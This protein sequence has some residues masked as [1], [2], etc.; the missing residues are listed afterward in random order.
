MSELE[1]RQTI[2]TNDD[3]HCEQRTLQVQQY[4]RQ[5]SEQLI[6]TNFS[7]QSQGAGKRKQIVRLFKLNIFHA[8]ASMVP[9]TPL[10]QRG[11]TLSGGNSALCPGVM[12]R[13]ALTIGFLGLQCQIVTQ[14][15]SLN[16]AN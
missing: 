12:N 3:I 14:W 9:K 5:G 15:G 2:V 10:S 1:E 4:W 6:I 8:G 16:N 11:K 13:K 7:L